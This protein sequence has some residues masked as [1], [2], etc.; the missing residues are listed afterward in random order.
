MY[1]YLYPDEYNIL[2]SDPLAKAIDQLQ[3][4]I[5]LRSTLAKI[6]STQ[7]NTNICFTKCQYYVLKKIMKT[8]FNSY[9]SFIVKY[10]A[11]SFSNR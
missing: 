10:M 2:T 5:L 1:V 3:L 8:S 9:A 7:L 11:K 6:Y 4:R